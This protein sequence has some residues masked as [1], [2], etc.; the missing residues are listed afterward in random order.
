MKVVIVQRIL[1]HY[2]I[3]FYQY[4][5]SIL[6]DSISLHLVYGQGNQDD[7]AKLDE[8]HLSWGTVIKNRY[9]GKLVWQPALPYLHDADL[10]I[11]ENANRLL[12]N[13]ILH[14]RYIIFKKRFAYWGH[15]KDFQTHS[16]LKNLLKHTYSKNTHWWF[17]YTQSGKQIVQ[18]AG[19]DSSRI[20]VVQNAIDTTALLN[21]AHSVTQ[22]EQ[23][24]LLTKINWDTSLS[25]HT[26]IYCGGM[27]TEKRIPF[28]LDC[29]HKLKESIPDFRILFIGSGPDK[30]LL[31]TA[32]KQHH[33]IHYAGP[34]FA[35]EKVVYYS[36]AQLA[37]MPGLVGLTIL[38]S[39][40]LQVPLIT[41][42]YPFHSPEIEYLQHNYNGCISENN[43][44]AYC[45]AVQKAFEE[46]RLNKLK[47]GCL[48]SSKKYTA[49]AMAQN[50]CNGI[51]KALGA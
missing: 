38:D 27:Y 46:P 21:I 6:P 8:A 49:Q 47:Q 1:T 5:Q 50:F 14:L 28:L 33:W 25:S 37:L 23:Q 18:Q 4:L 10:V 34:A 24:E 44:S 20:T 19:F 42:N 16:K 17:C 51:V 36:L 11:V 22:K 48:E 45:D 30:H 12:L 43:S 39:F 31:E 29:C 7:S 2:R 32:S 13:F 26:A 35:R 3:D 41:T 15:G 9:W 40:A